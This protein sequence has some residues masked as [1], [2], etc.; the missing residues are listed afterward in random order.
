MDGVVKHPF[1]FDNRV[2]YAI[3]RYDNDRYTNTYERKDQT[4]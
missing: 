2:R 4:R 1:Q 3:I